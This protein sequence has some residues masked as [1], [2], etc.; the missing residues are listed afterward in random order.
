MR[1]IKFRAKAHNE[2]K[3][4]V[5]GSLIVENDK[6]IIIREE[7]TQKD[8]PCNDETVGEFT[9]LKAK[10]KEIYEGDIVRCVNDEGEYYFPDSPISFNEGTF[11]WGQHTTLKDRIKECDGNMEIIGNIYEDKK[12]LKGVNEL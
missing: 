3:G 6:S 9:G 4:C 8:W 5:Y 2:K 12:F 1:T 7:R 10:G 11:T